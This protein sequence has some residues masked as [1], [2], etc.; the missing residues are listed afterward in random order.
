MEFWCRRLLVGQT[1]TPANI[2]YSNQAFGPDNGFASHGIFNVRRNPI[3]RL[4]FGDFV[5]AAIEPATD[6]LNTG[7]SFFTE[8]TFHKI[9]AR[10]DLDLGVIK[11]RV[12]GGFNTYEHTDGT[13]DVAHDVDSYIIA[14]ALKPSLVTFIVPA[15][16]LSAIIL[17]PMAWT[18]LRW[19]TP[20]FGQKSEGQRRLQI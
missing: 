14:W 5:I 6:T 2:T 8:V 11:F 7:T 3:V 17:I 9:E 4:E 10:Y 18:I 13:T 1:Y 15:A 12:A 19:M 20:D 16:F